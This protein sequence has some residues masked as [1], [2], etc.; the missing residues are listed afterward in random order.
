LEGVVE[1]LPEVAGGVVEAV[2]PVPAQPANVFNDGFD[3]FFFFLF[4]V[5]VVEAEI[6]QPAEFGGD[7]EIEASSATI[8][9]IKSSLAGESLS[10]MIHPCFASSIN[11]L[12]TKGSILAQQGQ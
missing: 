8:C 10:F 7:A 3:V 1:H 4:R 11:L 5:G 9:R 2:L 6:A 12:T